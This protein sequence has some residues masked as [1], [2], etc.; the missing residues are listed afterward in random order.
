M[1]TNHANAI[2]GLSIAT[3]VLAA[4]GILGAVI[5]V[6]VA[7]V[8]GTMLLEMGPDM[9]A[10]GYA[11]GSTH[12]LDYEYN[13][14][15]EQA[16]AMVSMLTSIVG[17]GVGIWMLICNV[18][19]LVAGIM[20]LRGYNKPEKL[21]NV[22]IWAIVGAVLSFLGGGIITMVLLIIVA[23]FANK[24]KKLYAGMASAGAGMPSA[25]PVAA[26]PVAPVAQPVAQP[27]VQP[28]A[29]PVA[30]PIAQP[31]TI[32]Q[33]STAPVADADTASPLNGSAQ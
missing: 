22:F 6:A 16:I 4:L 27:V 3:I 13:M 7:N 29:Q 26:A 5:T 17:G 19:I 25:A 1:Q 24:D 20:G 11:S 18:V 33:P 10:S 12:G 14:S 32:T 8:M 9:V 21:G 15:D 23:V 2:K 30:Q 31:S 28:G